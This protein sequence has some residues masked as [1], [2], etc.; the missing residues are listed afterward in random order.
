MKQQINTKQWNELSDK[1]KDE[2]AHQIDMYYCCDDCI[3]TE[4]EL[5]SIGQMIEFLGKDLGEIQNYD[6]IWGVELRNTDLW[7]LDELCDALWEAVKQKL[8]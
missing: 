1:Q 5:P 6:L 2:L 3:M 8:K 7:E 4:S